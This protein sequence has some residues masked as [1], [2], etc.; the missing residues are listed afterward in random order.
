MAL[1]IL[2]KSTV[3]YLTKPG[4]VFD[5]I[6]SGVDV[7]QLICQ[8]KRD[9]FDIRDRI[10]HLCVKNKWWDALRALVEAGLDPDEEDCNDYQGGRS[11]LIAVVRCERD[12]PREFVLEMVTML[13]NAGANPFVGGFCDWLFASKKPMTIAQMRTILSGC[14]FFSSDN[15]YHS[16]CW[17]R[18]SA[19]R[20]NIEHMEL[21][22]KCG[23]NTRCRPSDDPPALFYAKSAA[24]VNLLVSY[25]AD[26]NHEAV[27]MY[28]GALVG[29]GSTPFEAAYTMDAGLDVVEALIECGAKPTGMLSDRP[30]CK[31][32]DH[33][34]TQVARWRDIFH[35][36]R[37]VW[38]PWRHHCAPRNVKQAVRTTM[39]LRSAGLGPVGMLPVELMFVIFEFIEPRLVE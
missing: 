38:K 32:S 34:E 1:Y 7:N 11:L 20:D 36:A 24:M 3:L 30:M 31:A 33:T 17:T 29:V 35:Y 22:L 5:L 15:R 8:T 13:I 2:L 6:A 27:P 21:L 37:F 16:A 4:D 14:R 26:P 23:A 39:V 12:M 19:M 18:Q 25:G 10:G 9:K 28:H